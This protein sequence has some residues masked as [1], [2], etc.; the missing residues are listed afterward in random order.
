MQRQEKL[1]W[2]TTSARQT[3]LVHDLGAPCMPIHNGIFAAMR[4][5]HTR[6]GGTKVPP[7]SC[8]SPPLPS[9]RA[10]RARV[11]DAFRLPPGCCCDRQ[12]LVATPRGGR[13]M[14]APTKRGRQRFMGWNLPFLLLWADGQWKL[15]CY[16]PCARSAPLFAA[17]NAATF[18]VCTYASAPA[19]RKWGDSQEGRN[20]VSP[21]LCARRPRRPHFHP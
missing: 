4:R 16:A 15:G 1:A 13:A 12:G 3:G 10:A 8:E 7:A 9:G 19:Q 14:R 17:A 6:G 11:S 2:A 5:R 20:F 18:W 21:L